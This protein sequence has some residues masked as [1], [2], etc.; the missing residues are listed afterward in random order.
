MKRWLTVLLVLLLLTGCG[1]D[2]PEETTGPATTA[3]T[4]PTEPDPGILLEDASVTKATKG[5]VWAYSLDETDHSLLKMGEKL[6]LRTNGPDGVRLTL[7][8]GERGAREAEVLLAGTSAETPVW[9]EEDRAAWYDADANSLVM[10][11]KKLRE[12]ERIR[13]LDTELLSMTLDPALETLYYSKTDSLWALDLETGIFRLLRESQG[14]T[15]KI[16]ALHGDLLLCRT[17]ENLEIISCRDGHTYYTGTALQQ[18]DGVEDAWTAIYTDGPVTEYLYGLGQEAKLF[19]PARQVQPLFYGLLED[20]RVLTAYA[21]ALELYDMEKGQLAAAVALDG[22]TLAGTPVANS[23]GIWFLAEDG[24]TQLLYR[25]QPE[26]SPAEAVAC[27]STRYTAEDPDTQALD[28]CRTYAESIGQT[29]GITVTLELPQALQRELRGQPEHQ[30]EALYTALEELE[31]VLSQFPEVFYQRVKRVTESRS[32]TV[33]LLRSIT[34]ASGETLPDVRGHQ[35]WAEGDAYILVAVGA[36]TRQQLYHQLWHMAETY[37][38]SRN[39]MLDTWDRMN[40]KDF[41]YLESYVGY[42]AMTEYLS[43]EDRA[44][45][46][47]F[48]MTFVREDRATV[49]EH[50]MLEGMAEA[51]ASETMQAKLQTL[52]Q[53]IRHAFKL[54]KSEETFLWEQYLKTE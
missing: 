37:V 30:A 50:A 23:L 33:S 10:L 48:S 54:E 1:A 6:L 24:Q 16:L 34:G 52:C 19:R 11:D 15:P 45:L 36:D 29:Y 4:T 43:G 35:A 25:W 21:G 47:S 8:A 41:A 42:E 51:F 40:P 46:N 12:Q 53:S 27:L 2:S 44:F 28:A 7:L 20:G 32:F 22:L 3:D 39:S 31:L 5:A 14:R 17:G 38:L 9:A 13:L 49:M 26:N 18:W